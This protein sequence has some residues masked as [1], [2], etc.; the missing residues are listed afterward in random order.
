[1]ITRNKAPIWRVG[2]GWDTHALVAGRRLVLGQFPAA[3]MNQVHA[4]SFNSISANKDRQIIYVGNVAFVSAFGPEAMAG[5]QTAIRGPTP[6]WGAALIAAR[7]VYP[8]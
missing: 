7:S 5:K 6:A 8:S 1:M 2:E 4:G 3:A